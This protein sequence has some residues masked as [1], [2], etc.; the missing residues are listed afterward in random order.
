VIRFMLCSCFVALLGVSVARAARPGAPE[1]PVRIAVAVDSKTGQLHVGEPT[2]VRVVIRNTTS[3]P[4][5]LVDWE[6]NPRS[7]EVGLRITERPSPPDA[8]RDGPEAAAEGVR[9][10]WAAPSKDWF[11]E[12]P[13]GDTVLA[14]TVTPLVP[15]WAEVGVRLASTTALYRDAGGEEVRVAD[16]WLGRAASSVRLPVASEMP[17]DMKERCEV[18]RKRVTDTSVP[19]GARK[20]MLA[21]AAAAKHYFAARFLQEVYQA[22]PPGP[23]RTAALEHLVDLAKLGTAYE[24]MPVLLG[25]MGSSLVPVETRVEILDWVAN[26]LERRGLQP[27]ADQGVHVYP[28]PLRDQARAAVRR[29]VFAGD[30][31]VASRA[32]RAV[33]N[34]E[35]DD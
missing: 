28:E 9:S 29:L 18:L 26:V 15:G 32:R 27:V 5:R 4:V 3:R 7:L 12:L 35:K 8:P 30:P 14:R 34:W 1:A 16:V 25:A 6:K 19:S 23:V 33:E 31:E 17:A 22:L 24:A 10:T 11:R 21:E 20:R 2:T 13:P